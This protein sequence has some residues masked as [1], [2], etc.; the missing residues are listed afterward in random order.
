[1]TKPKIVNVASVRKL[2][3]FRYPGGKTWLVPYAREWLRS[4]KAKPEHFIEPFVGGG[5][6]SLTVGFECLAK[7]VTMVE[8]DAEVAAV[9]ETILSDKAP[10]LCKKILEFDLTVEN[11]REELASD[12]EQV[13]DIAFRTILKNR[14]F[15]GGIL[16]KG[17]NM[18]KYGEGG[19]GIASRWY[20]KTLSTRITD[21]YRSRE[22]FTFIQGDG[23]QVMNAFAKK[24]KAAFFID[25]PYTAGKK[26]KRAG[27]RLYTHSQIDHEALFDAAKSVKGDFLMTYDNDPEVLEMA[28]SR[29]FDTD[30][31]PMK[32]THHAEM[33][34]LIIGRDLDWARRMRQPKPTTPFLFE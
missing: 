7:Q 13:E 18:L 31:I 3:P 21:I 28:K 10:G 17:A 8:L 29:G 2:S 4:Q 34:E 12:S 22:P 33:T 5:I 23:I 26:G 1:M 25:P 9:W 20:A 32:N 24:S 15:H 27:N 16:A 6:I 14:T 19:K 11:V 30:L